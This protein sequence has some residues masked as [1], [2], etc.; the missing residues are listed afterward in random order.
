[1]AEKASERPRRPL[2]AVDAVVLTKRGSIVLVKRRKPPYQGHWALPGGFVEYGET[3]EQA[4]VREVK[5]ETGLEVEVKGLIGV[6]SKPD[7]DPRGHVV[8]VAF[9]TLEVGGQLRGSE[10]TEVSEFKEPPEQLAFDHKDI[11]QDGLKLACSM[12]IL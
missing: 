7:R 12:K 10:E 2:L 1:M 4:V 8:S 3:V 6:Y 11:L 9:L 5:E